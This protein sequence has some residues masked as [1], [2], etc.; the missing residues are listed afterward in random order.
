VSPHGVAEDPPAPR[1]G[2]PP[3]EVDTSPAVARQLL[4]EQHPDLAEL[5]IVPAASGWDNTTHRL[6]DEFA[7]RLPRRALAAPLLAHEQRWLP[8]LAPRLPLPV[9][10]PVRV[11]HPARDFPFAWS[12]VPWFAGDT[13]EVAGVP[14]GAATALGRFLAALHLPAP[15]EA[16]ANPARGVPLAERS[17]AIADRLAQ[18]DASGL[19]DVVPLRVAVAQALAAPPAEARVWLHG[20]LHPRNLLVAEGRIAAVLDW[21][22]VTA[23]DPATDLALAWMLFDAPERRTLLAARGGVD[24]ALR[25]CAR[26]WAVL[27]GAMLLSVGVADRDDGFTSVGRR[28]LERVAADVVGDPDRRDER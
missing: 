18:V 28:T 24:A 6:G 22:D 26:G 10:A 23:G 21:G 3:S 2:T 27:F 1:R 20:D 4:A 13:A 9:P 7:L 17:S 15:A 14:A 25:A 11:G 16:P 5:P 8:E 19:V 12:V